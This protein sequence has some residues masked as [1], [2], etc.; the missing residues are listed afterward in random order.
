[1]SDDV[2]VAQKIRCPRQL[3]LQQ[4][5]VPSNRLLHPRRAQFHLAP[6]PTNTQHRPVIKSP[7]VRTPLGRC[8]A[9]LM[10]FRP[11]TGWKH[12]HSGGGGARG[13]ACPP[14]FFLI[15]NNARTAAGRSGAGT[16]ARPRTKAGR[17]RRGRSGRQHTMPAAVLQRAARAAFAITT[18]TSCVLLVAAAGPAHPARRDSV[19]PGTAHCGG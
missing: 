8:W 7:P 4:R 14:L 11:P 12:R 16:Q 9:N 1:M 15:D 19:P 13:G 6:F 17:R 3:H 2:C 10:F 18:A 5:F